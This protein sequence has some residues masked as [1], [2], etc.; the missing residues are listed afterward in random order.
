VNS[1]DFTKSVGRLMVKGSN[2]LVKYERERSWC[3]WRYRAEC[4]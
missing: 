1:T 3:S 4:V 2:D